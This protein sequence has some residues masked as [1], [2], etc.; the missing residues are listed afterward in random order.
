LCVRTGED[1]DARI[2]LLPEEFSQALA[3]AKGRHVIHEEVARRL[4][5][6]ASLMSEREQQ[7]RNE[8]EAQADLI[9]RADI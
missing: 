1:A 8:A 7:A 6:E 2:V 3:D 9:P 5:D 4:E